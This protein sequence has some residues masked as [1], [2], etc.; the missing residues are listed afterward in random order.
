M[1]LILLGWTSK[2][3]RC[4]DVE[5]NFRKGNEEVYRISLIQMPNGTGK[6]TM[7][8]LL[9]AVLSG[10]AIKW[11]EKEILEYQRPDKDVNKGE[12][13]VS[14]KIDGK[15][16]TIKLSLNFDD[17]KA[18]YTTTSG[19]A[20]QEKG[21]KPPAHLK[22]LLKPE[23]INLFLFDGEFANKLCDSSFSKA[24]NVIDG[25][26]QLY[27][28]KEIS[29][30]LE[31][32]WLDKS[33]GSA[34]DKSGFTRR[35]NR[36]QNLQ[37]HLEGL[38]IK[39]D[40]LRSKENVLK[41]E[42]EVLDKQLREIISD[43][44]EYRER[45]TLAKSNKDIASEKVA[46]CTREILSLSRNPL[47][48]NRQF[49]LLATELKENL[50][51]LKLPRATSREFFTEL[52]ES[53]ICVCGDPIDLRKKEIILI[54]ADEYLGEP[55]TGIINSIKSDIGGI[56]SSKE[57]NTKKYTELLNTLSSELEKERKYITE[58]RS[59]EQTVTENNSAEDINLKRDSKRKEL[60]GVVEMI[61]FMES[62]NPVDEGDDTGNIKTA[63]E[64]LENAAKELSEISQTME[65]KNK[66]TILNDILNKSKEL[67]RNL[68]EKDLVRE[69]NN[70][71]KVILGYNEIELESIKNSLH[72][73]KRNR[74]S[75]G[76]TLALAYA[77]L[78][79]LF[80]R[81]SHELPFIVDSPAG[82]LDGTVRKEVA[83]V[84]SGLSK[85]FIAFTISTE[86]EG[87]VT[88]LEKENA[89]IQFLTLFR[90]NEKAEKYKSDLIKFGVEEKH[91]SYLVSDRNFFN[92]FDDT[93]E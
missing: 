55:E 35:R 87:F 42:L 37:K 19:I 29:N 91:D 28:F 79:T 68:L 52:I 57:E 54:K 63:T 26:F 21:Y 44:K 85:Q 40:E 70:K 93:G 80:S 78:G 67:T 50:D 73:K 27:L 6:T 7:L 49:G 14:L 77:F 31:E 62:T 71:L 84:I 25:L 41:E 39:R 38:K 90:K 3:M 48:M 86:R 4:P 56:E 22:S 75:V 24:D 11:E 30:E 20:G 47:Y 12:F 64:N 66:K 10:E 60:H 17:L 69:T 2:G 45:W 18:Q 76:Q 61:D 58:L 92:D 65:L 33:Q 72:I 9:R 88:T 82:S 13:S 23:F 89:N 5:I 83:K 32:Y 16:L 43:N 46:T 36:H 51:K 1:K 74:A 15:L 34:R 59:I 81:G 8:N 53:G